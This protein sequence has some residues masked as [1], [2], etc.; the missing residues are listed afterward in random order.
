MCVCLTR[1]YLTKPHSLLWDPWTVVKRKKRWRFTAFQPNKLR[2][3]RVKCEKHLLVRGSCQVKHNAQDPGP[4]S[5][6]G[7]EWTVF[8]KDTSNVLSS[9][10]S[11][12]SLMHGI[13]VNLPNLATNQ[14][15]TEK[16]WVSGLQ[17]G[18]Q[19][20]VSRTWESYLWL[21]DWLGY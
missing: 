4:R 6:I 8:S 14:E 21:I 15:S 13:S 17:S 20:S 3:R 11:P 1:F 19:I 9:H 10:K 12:V 7:A 2:K 18:D 16:R 5:S